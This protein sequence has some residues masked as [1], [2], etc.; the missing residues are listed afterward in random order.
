[1]KH[2][3]RSDIANVEIISYINGFKSWGG[4]G[5]RINSICHVNIGYIA[6]NGSGLK[7]TTTNG[8]CYTFNCH[9]PE[10]IKKIL[11]DW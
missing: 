2:M 9:Q 11:D 7:I 8:K 5:I 1:M 4:Y 6:Y 3:N 10:T